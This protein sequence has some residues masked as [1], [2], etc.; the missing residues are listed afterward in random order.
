MRRASHIVTINTHSIASAL[1]VLALSAI[2]ASCASVPLSTVMRMAPFSEEKFIGLRPDDIGIRIRFSD[3]FELDVANSRLAIEVASS[4]GVH[5]AQFD[6][7]QTGMQPVRLSSGLFSRPQ[8]GVEYDLQLSSGSKTR[9]HDL[10]A[11]VARAKVQDIGVR[12]MPKL[13][14]KPDGATS[15]LVWIDLRLTREQGYFAL[16]EAASISLLK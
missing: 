4:A 5:D 12:V 1:T 9:F 11:F 7:E 8:P 14:S 2:L 3:G 15:V 16:L 6:L 13:A 10:Q